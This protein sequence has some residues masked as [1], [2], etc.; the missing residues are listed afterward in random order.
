MRTRW[1]STRTISPL[2]KGQLRNKN[3]N[4][5]GKREGWYLQKKCGYKKIKFQNVPAMYP[6]LLPDTGEQQ[7]TLTETKNAANEHI[8]RFARLLRSF[9][10]SSRTKVWCERRDCNPLDYLNPLSKKP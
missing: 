4:V 8:T 7:K 6:H 2:K 3:T 1:A 9:N 10:G 5:L